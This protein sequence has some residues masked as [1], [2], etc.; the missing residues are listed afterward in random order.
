VI[1]GEFIGSRMGLGH[2][3]IYGTQVFKLDWVI[4]SIVILCIVAIL[5]YGLIGLMENV[6]IK[7]KSS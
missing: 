7:E 3:I 1:I 2:L 6:F 4:L 5:L